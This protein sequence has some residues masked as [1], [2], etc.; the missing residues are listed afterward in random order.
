MIIYINGQW[1]EHQQAVVS[2]YDHGFLYGM[3]LFETF[4]T[5]GGKPFLL[6]E[7]LARLEKDCRALD[8]RYSP[9]S[10]TIAAIIDSLLDKN[11]L[12]EAYI[13]LSVSAG[14]GEIGLPAEGYETPTVIVYGKPLPPRPDKWEKTARP[15]QRLKLSRN[16][17]EAGWR[18]KSFHYMNNILAKRELKQYPWISGTGAE[19]LLLNEKGY[20]AEGMVSNLFFVADGICYTPALDTGILPGITRDFVIRLCEARSVPVCVGHFDWDHL[21]AAEEVF[22]TNSVQEIIPINALYDLGGH[23]R[24]VGSGEPGSLTRTLYEDYQRYCSL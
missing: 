3:G 22:V 2:V 16:S 14:I 19:G 1:T 11:Q 18:M 10:S 17:P 24:Q 4:R 8:I 15:L 6:E 12:S 13:R 7:H 23:R 20:L 9:D 21:L 5:Y